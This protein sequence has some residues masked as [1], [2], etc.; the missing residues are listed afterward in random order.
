MIAKS[1]LYLG[2]YLFGKQVDK[3]KVR[4]YIVRIP[5]GGMKIG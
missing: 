1:L 4:V 5:H 2:M 3:I